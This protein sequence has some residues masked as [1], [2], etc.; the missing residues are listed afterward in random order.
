MYATI[1]FGTPS[2]GIL[3]YFLIMFESVYFPKLIDPVLPKDDNINFWVYAPYLDASDYRIRLEPTYD[4]WIFQSTQ[5]N[6]EM[7][8]QIF[9]QQIEVIFRPEVFQYPIEGETYLTYS[10][11]VPI[12]ATTYDEIEFY[13]ILLVRQDIAQATQNEI[14][15]SLSATFTVCVMVIMIGLS[16]IVLATMCVAW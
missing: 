16:V 7:T 5:G 10:Q 9:N 1:G 4:Q 8:E 6:V 3:G 2:K 12:S 11:A 15:L 14:K 13:L